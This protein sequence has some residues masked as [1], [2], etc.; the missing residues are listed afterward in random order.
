MTSVPWGLYQLT[1]IV[2]VGFVYE[3]R[4]QYQTSQ[5]DEVGNWAIETGDS[6]ASSNGLALVIPWAITV[7]GTLPW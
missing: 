4:Y 6:L 3:N 2:S 7:T 1:L 5:P